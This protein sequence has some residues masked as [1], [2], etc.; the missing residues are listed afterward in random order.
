MDYNIMA[1]GGKCP[2]GKLTKLTKTN[3][4]CK[5]VFGLWKKA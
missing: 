4:C 1:A 5:D 3:H 2:E